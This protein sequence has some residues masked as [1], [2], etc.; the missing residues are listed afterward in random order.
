[1][2]SS[3]CAERL[4]AILLLA[5]APL[6]A[7]GCAPGGPGFDS[8][9]PGRL[10]EHPVFQPEPSRAARRVLLAVRSTDGDLSW[11]RPILER[12]PRYSKVELLVPEELESRI[13]EELLSRPVPPSVEI[14]PYGRPAP[15]WSAFFLLLPDRDRLVR[16][17]PQDEELAFLH[18]T[19]WAQD[20]FEVVRDGA[21]LVLLAPW[22]QRHLL[23]PPDAAPGRL[24][25]DTAFV[26]HL[27]LPG[28]RVAV[29]PAAFNGGNVVADVVGGRRVVIVGGDAVRKTRTLARAFGD[30]P[31][32]PAEL[33]RLFGRALG[34][35]ETVILD[36]GRP[37]PALL[38]HLDQVI[39]PLGEDRI[40]L[41]LPQVGPGDPPAVR[42]AA[43]FAVRLRSRL[44]R[45]GYRIVEIPVSG[46]DLAAYRHPLNAVPYTDAETGR[47]T[48]L[49]PRFP[50]GAAF[51]PA[52]F[53][54]A[55]YRVVEVPTAASD[56]KGG[57]H[58]L[59]NVLE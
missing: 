30:A 7:A 34:A 25:P 57:V 53:A 17:L 13:R 38:Y 15:P 21:E 46:A 18:G 32:G 37:Q 29:L 52:P 16:V 5:A 33:A 22:V 43:A 1:M 39:L 10:P 40:A 51:D 23:G 42:D 45:L 4:A 58:C 55:G 6:A 31:P 3:A 50:G 36:P 20:L 28:A 48:L 8:P 11:Q 41:A 44:S 2:N 9:R 49:L 19:R 54:E 47:R 27:R 24:V 35:D 56:L 12:L 59:V 14:V 26:D